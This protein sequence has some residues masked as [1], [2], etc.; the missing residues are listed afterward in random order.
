MTE[1]D[2]LN[3]ARSMTANEVSLFT[4]IVTITFAMVVAIYYF[5]SQAGI[6]M[7]IFAFVAY[8]FG[9]FLFLGQ[10]LIEENIKFVVI[11]T[12]RAL[13]H[14]SDVTQEYLGVT[15]SWLGHL[16][17]FL[18]NGSIWILWLGVFYL[19][20]FGRRHLSPKGSRDG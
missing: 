17:A 18:F 6:A 11:A 12:Q 4:Q 5:L 7:K 19:L 1:L 8:S 20:F 2:L 14:K 16:T 10:I 13:L 15:A 9:L 3:L